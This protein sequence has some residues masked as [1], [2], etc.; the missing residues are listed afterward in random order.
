LTIALEHLI[1]ITLFGDELCLETIQNGGLTAILS[2]CRM[3]TTPSETLRLLLRAMAVLCGVSKG[4][5]QLLSMAGLDTVVQILCNGNIAC[6]V[7]AAGV[8]TQ[9]TNP[10]HAFAKLHTLIPQIVT[11][12]LDVID[13]SHSAE[14]LLLCTAAIANLTLQQPS[15]VELLYRYNAI[16]RIISAFN[17]PNCSTI[18]VQEQVATILSRLAARDYEEALIAQGA[19]PV[20]L[21]M[22]TSE[23]PQH[24]DYCRRIRYK[25]AVCIGTLASKGRGLK[26]L[27]QN[28]AYESLC[29]VLDMEQSRSNPLVMICENIRDRLESKYQLESAV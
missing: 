17:Q 10:T 11:R 27:H 5:I 24:S 12:L 22:L 15:V 7:E 14:A 16:L 2:F 13:E 18:F 1:H 21:K 4:C 6:S 23:H 8:L 9:L 29:Q 26:A 28:K 3:T 20:L 19:I 25:A